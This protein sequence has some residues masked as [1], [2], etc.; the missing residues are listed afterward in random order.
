[1]PF[2]HWEK[3]WIRT[4]RTEVRGC[5]MG[6]LRSFS[7][8]LCCSLAQAPWGWGWS[9][10]WNQAV[11]FVLEGRCHMGHLGEIC[12]QSRRREGVPGHWLTLSPSQDIIQPLSCASVQV[13]QKTQQPRQPGLR[14]E[15]SNTSSKAAN[16]VLALLSPWA[17]FLPA[18]HNP[19]LSLLVCDKSAPSRAPSFS[20][21][22][23]EAW[24][25]YLCFWGVH[26]SRRG[27]EGIGISNF[28][29][30]NSVW[31]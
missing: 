15:E 12:A 1:M 11:F 13:L 16:Y 2:T 27:V 31:R 17:I 28:C 8:N 20:S 9:R 14:R 26:L 10:W 22:W 21:R 19:L 5:S 25:L 7:Y 18:R 30:H 6:I 4:V 29:K 3:G 23:T 24:S